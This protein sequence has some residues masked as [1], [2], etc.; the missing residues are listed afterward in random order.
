LYHTDDK[1]KA[2]SELARVTKRAGW[3]GIILNDARHMHE[4]NEAAKRT[5]PQIKL[6]PCD[7]D[8][9]TSQSALPLLK[10]VFTGIEIHSYSCEMLISEARDI[11]TYAK[12]S[13]TFQKSDLPGDFWYK[14]EDL[15]NSEIR[16]DGAVSVNK[17]S[18][19]YI[20]RP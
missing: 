7:A 6:A 5:A 10:E 11:V 8:L 20:C 1:K 2:L 13:E 14:F 3:V 16:A 18:T 15:L 9:F 4:I 19:L 17:K 12:S